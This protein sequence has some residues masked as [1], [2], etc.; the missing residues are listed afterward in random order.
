MVMS[1]QGKAAIFGLNF[2]VEGV[3]KTEFTPPYPKM[4]DLWGGRGDHP[5]LQRAKN[6]TLSR[7]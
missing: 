7:D 6:F 3:K 1:G 4:F 2:W 5:P